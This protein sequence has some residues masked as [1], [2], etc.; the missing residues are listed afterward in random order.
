MAEASAEKLKVFISYSRKDSADFADE[1][2]AGLELTGFAPFLDLHDISAGEEWE[3]RLGDLIEKSDTVVFVVSPKAVKSERCVWEI[4]K[5][6]AWSKRLLPVIY[7]PV[8]DADIPEQLRRLQFVRFDTGPGLAR[9]LTQLAE[10]LRQ[11]LDWIREHTRLGELAVR[12]R[13]RGKSAS[14]LL[15]GDEL[16]AAKAWAA[17]RKPA[18]PEITEAQRALLDASEVADAAHI[19]ESNATRVQMQRM[20]AIAGWLFVGILAGLAYAGWLNQ[21]YL[22]VRAVMLA[23]LLWPKVLTPEAERALRPKGYFRECANCPEMVVVPAGEFMMGSPADEKGHSNDEGPQRMVR[24]FKP[25]AVSRFEVTFDE[26]D[27]CVA[28]GGCAYQYQ[29]ADQGWGRNRRPVINVSWDDAQ[30]YLAWLSRRT[31]KLYRL[32][33]EAEWEYAARAGSDKPYSWGDDMGKGTCAGCGSEWDDKQTAPV[34]SFAANA[35]GLYDMHGNV[36]EWVQDCYYDNYNEAPTDGSARVSGE[37]SYRV[38]RGG[39]WSYDPRPL[40]AAVRKWLSSDGRGNILGF[41]VG[42]TL[43]P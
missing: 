22:K 40:R 26:W 41:R 7:K 29:P 23:E 6:L 5:A 39:S 33:S 15:H 19:A 28:H 18:A 21:A 25:F 20:R 10:A 14:L 35:F 2:V 27:A 24:F 31:G 43:T 17:K 36:W 11:D 30:Q 1:L 13:A 16:D 38:I 34:G 42:R 37:C 32:L 8:A 9:P 3:A 4:D 12:W